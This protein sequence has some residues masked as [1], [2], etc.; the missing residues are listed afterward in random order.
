MVVSSGVECGDEA[1]DTEEEGVLELD[2]EGER[3]RAESAFGVD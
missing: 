3:A 1:D 2:W